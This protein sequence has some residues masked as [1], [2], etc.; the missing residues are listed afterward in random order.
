M[1]LAEVHAKYLRKIGYLDVKG[2]IRDVFIWSVMEV[3]WWEKVTVQQCGRDEAQFTVWMSGLLR[4]AATVDIASPH[5][6]QYLKP[7]FEPFTSP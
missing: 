2:S 3:Y 5:T 1:L 6:C 7:P 4:G